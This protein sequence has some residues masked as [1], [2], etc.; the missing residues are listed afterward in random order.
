MAAQKKAL[1][2]GDDLGKAL[3]G[4]VVDRVSAASSDMDGGVKA[5]VTHASPTLTAL[6]KKFLKESGADAVEAPVDYGQLADEET[7]M[8]RPKA[9]GDAK[10]AY[11]GPDGKIE[12]V[13][14]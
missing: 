10:V 12:I 3:P 8:V 1:K 4:W 5:M 7:M 9:G 6:R 11:R 14:G 2:D 13:Q